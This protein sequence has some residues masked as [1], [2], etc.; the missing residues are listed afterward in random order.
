MLKTV[1]LAPIP[2]AR[3]RTT[4]A[5]NPGYFLI[6]RNAWRKSFS[7]LNI[8][9]LRETVFAREYSSNST[10]NG[11]KAESADS[12]AV[13]KEDEGCSWWIFVQG[14]T[15]SVRKWTTEAG[16]RIAAGDFLHLHDGSW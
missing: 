15:A 10:A 2:S 8:H 3:V 5:V 4:T 9:T 12:T 7:R 11:R 1:A 6:W 16:L 13:P 14:R